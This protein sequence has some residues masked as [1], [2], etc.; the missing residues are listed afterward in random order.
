MVRAR[1]G[2]WSFTE[3]TEYRK[4]AGAFIDSDSGA[5]YMENKVA[6]KGANKVANKAD[7][8]LQYPELILHNEIFI[9][10][11]GVR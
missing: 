2:W 3:N 9:G 1:P 6:N 11:R 4:G 7:I 5:S 10:K 8:K